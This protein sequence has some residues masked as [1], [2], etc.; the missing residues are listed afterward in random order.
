[1]SFPTLQAKTRGVT[2]RKTRSLREQGQVPGVVYGTGQDPQNVQF[3]RNAFV[4]LYNEQGSSSIVELDVDG[5]KINVLMHDYQL[6]PLR[7]EVIHADFR[8]VD[9]NK[10]LEADVRLVHIGEAAAV[11]A[12][13][14]TLVTAIDS[15]TIRALPANLMK[16]I[17]IDLSALATFDDAI[18]VGDLKLPEGVEVVTDPKRTI[19]VVSPPRTE[20]EMAA[21]DEA[22]EEDVEGVGVEG[23]EGEGEEGEEG[24]AEAKAEGEGTEE[25][26]NKGTEEQV[27]KKK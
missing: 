26:K 3:D 19:A 2:G 14:G 4:K 20:A 18:R 10:P 15:I 23:E 1:M 24:E 12:L 5:K 13:G 8:A 11:K 27:E 17:E 22:V 16:S 21:L 6:D 25:Q 7:D 9:M